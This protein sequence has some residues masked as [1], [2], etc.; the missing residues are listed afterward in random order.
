MLL[1]ILNKLIDRVVKSLVRNFDRFLEVKLV[2]FE[3]C[4]DP[5]F[6]VYIGVN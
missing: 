3:R 1:V 2:V 4:F 5:I 6:M